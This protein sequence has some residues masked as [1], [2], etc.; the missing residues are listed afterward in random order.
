MPNKPYKFPNP[1]TYALDK[2]VVF[3]PKERILKLYK[4]STGKT[5]T[6]LTSKIVLWFAKESKAKGW[7]GCILV[8]IVQTKH[9][10]GCILANQRALNL[11]LKAILIPN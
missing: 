10:A 4:Q 1:E 7:A 5:H 2:P 3:C 11:T 6:S 9:H 8:P